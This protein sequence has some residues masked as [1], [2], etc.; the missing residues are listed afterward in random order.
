ME[1]NDLNSIKLYRQL[2][3]STAGEKIS[4]ILGSVAVFLLMLFGVFGLVAM[5]KDDVSGAVVSGI[6]LILLMAMI[7][8]FTIKTVKG[9]RK[10]NAAIRKRLS[11]L[12]Y[13]DLVSVEEQIARS[14]FLYRTFYMLDDYFYVPSMKLMIKYEDINGYKT[15]IHSTN[16]MKDGIKLKITD[17][18]NAE[19]EFWIKKWKDYYGGI[20]WFNDQMEEKINSHR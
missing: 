3:P 19:Y 18:D 12:T 2:K 5:V 11:E 7:S 4:V 8:Y 9:K 1:S 15:I 6:I 16:G 10:R 20:M 17:K 14:A 13:Y